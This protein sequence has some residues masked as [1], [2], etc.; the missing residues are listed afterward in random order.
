MLQ[1]LP[2]FDRGREAILRALSEGQMRP[3]GRPALRIVASATSASS[4][5]AVSDL[6]GF[7]QH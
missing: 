7:L 5:S 6:K 3:D 4:Y 2:S 1:E